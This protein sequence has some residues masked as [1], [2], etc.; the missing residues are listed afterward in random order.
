MHLLVP[1]SSTGPLTPGRAPPSLYQ[2]VFSLL[3]AL[4][5]LEDRRGAFLQNVDN[6]LPNYMAPRQRRQHSSI[7]PHFSW[8]L[9]TS[10]EENLEHGL[11][12][13]CLGSTGSDYGI[14]IAAIGL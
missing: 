4:F 2:N 14:F 3:G 7:F 1:P 6:D 5:Y 9:Y 8:S 13:A 11:E 12:T 10:G